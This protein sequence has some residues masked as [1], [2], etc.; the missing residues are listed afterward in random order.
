M[1]G[2]KL[3]TPTRPED[4]STFEG[5]TDLRRRDTQRV[6]GGTA[7]RDTP[8]QP[9]AAAAIGLR[10]ATTKGAESTQAIQERQRSRK[11]VVEARSARRQALWNK[12]DKAREEAQ[13]KTERLKPFEP[14]YS[15]P[16]EEPDDFSF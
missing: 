11:V 16:D 9:S 5:R 7:R 15:S 6:L 8:V 4:A 10:S 12:L 13:R 2:Q 14:Q 3:P 1:S